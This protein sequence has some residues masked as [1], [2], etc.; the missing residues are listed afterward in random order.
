M[1][2]FID[3]APFH[4]WID[5]TRTPPQQHWSV[6]LPVLVTEEGLPAPPA[7]ASPQDW[8]F[9]TGN[10][11]EAFAWRQH[12][13]DADLDPDVRRDLGVVTVTSAFGSK[14]Q[15]P[16]RL[17][18]LWLVS[19]L[20]TFQGQPW[21]LELDPGLPF[22][23]VATLPDPNFHRPLIGLR[24]L[25]RA[26]LLVEVNCRQDTVSVWTPDVTGQGP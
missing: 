10:R 26:G 15:L 8:V 19:N 17:V 11:G 5:Q 18:D 20:P 24:A 21:R 4:C 9:D 6:V 1:P 13:L 12:L 14:A 2:L 7:H 23:D 3:R 22:R 25:R 16:I